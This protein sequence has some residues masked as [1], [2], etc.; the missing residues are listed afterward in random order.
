MSVLIELVGAIAVLLW[1]LRMVR[2][3]MMRA[4]GS[5]LKR[6]ARRNEGKL[7]PML[8]SG[9]LFAILIQSSTATAI[10][11]AS[12]SGQNILSISSALIVILGADIG[13]AVAVILASQNIT[14]L[15]CS[16]FDWHLWVFIYPEK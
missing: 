4:Y 6:L 14:V 10:I 11:V 8:G 5:N 13:T 7:I 3:G 12:F 1:G 15:S 9:F 16:S 2:T